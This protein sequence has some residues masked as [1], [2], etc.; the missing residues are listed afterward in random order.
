[1]TPNP[2][3]AALRVRVDETDSSALDEHKRGEGGG[4]DEVSTARLRRV[5]LDDRSEPIEIRVEEPVESN[6]RSVDPDLGPALAPAR[7]ILFG[8]VLGT[9]LWLGLWQAVSWLIA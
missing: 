5:D 7:G 8:V 2:S 4:G 9:F 1:M 3:T 6:L